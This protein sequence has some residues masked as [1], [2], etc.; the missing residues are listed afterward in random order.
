MSD[1]RSGEGEI[2]DNPGTSHYARKH[3]SAQKDIKAGF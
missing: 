1:S 3:K 2:Q